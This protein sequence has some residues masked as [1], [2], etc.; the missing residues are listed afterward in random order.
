M[1]ARDLDGT[2]EHRSAEIFPN[3]FLKLEILTLCHNWKKWKVEALEQGV[4]YVQS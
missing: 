3:K 1:F 4:K 2:L